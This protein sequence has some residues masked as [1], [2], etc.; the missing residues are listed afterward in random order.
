MD[1]FLFVDTIEE[2]VL[3]LSCPKS[4]RINSI[5]GLALEVSL[6]RAQ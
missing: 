1:I 2:A 3:S 4:Y 5:L 6:H